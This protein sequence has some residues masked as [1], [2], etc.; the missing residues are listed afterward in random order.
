M[1]FSS[2]TSWWSMT[3]FTRPRIREYGFHTAGAM[4]ELARWAIPSTIV[5]AAALALTRLLSGHGSISPT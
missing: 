5:L 4:V 2:P 3:T 1:Y